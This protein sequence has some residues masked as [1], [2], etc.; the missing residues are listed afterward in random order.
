MYS[1]SSMAGQSQ[2][3][4]FRE[5]LRVLLLS[6]VAVIKICKKDTLRECPKP[7]VSAKINFEVEIQNTICLPLLQN[8]LIRLRCLFLIPLAFNL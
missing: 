1:V 4:Y 8:V 3:H 5:T 2:C 7:L 6:S